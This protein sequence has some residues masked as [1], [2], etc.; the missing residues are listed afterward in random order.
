MPRLARAASASSAA[1][2]A[3]SVGRADEVGDADAARPAARRA[4]P[5]GCGR[6]AP[7]GPRRPSRITR[8]EPLT[9]QSPMQRRGG[10][11]RRACRTCPGR[12]RRSSR[13]RRGRTARCAARRAL[14]AVDLEGVVAR[15]GPKTVPPP[16]HMRRADRAGAGAAGALLAP[17]LGA[18]AADLAAGLGRVRALAAG[19]QL[20]AHGLVHERAV[21][22]GAEGGVVELD[23]AAAAEV[24]GLGAS[25]R[26]GPPRRR[27]AGRGP[28]RAPAA[29]SAAVELDD[30]QPLL[31]D[32][33]V[34]HLA[35]AADA[36][37]HAGG[38][39]RR[40]RWSPGRARCASRGTW[41]RCEKLWRL[42][43]P[44]KPLPFEV[45]GD[46]HALARPRRPRR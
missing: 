9:P 18:A 15:R 7:P 29:G 41:G 27:C 40:R 22:R 21:E 17:R 28:S 4:R 24:A 8:T 19:V 46:L 35:G 11:R 33:L 12:R 23:G 37:H 42:M 45:P 2:E 26:C 25:H 44:W 6:R 10:L 30:R 14:L 38:P 32:A 20:G 36:L 13:A 39:A 5:R 31:R 43:V 1:W 34:A 3:S 16:V